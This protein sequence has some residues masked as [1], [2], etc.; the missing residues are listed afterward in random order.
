MNLQVYNFPIFEERLKF[1]KNPS[2]LALEFAE[3][4]PFDAILMDIQ[5]PTLDG[6]EATQQLRRSTNERLRNIPIIAFTAEAA[7][8]SHQDYLNSGF[9]DCMTKPFQPEQLFAVLR[10]YRISEQPV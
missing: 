9:N 4:T 8:E 3:K 6:K 5:M 7:V 10:K 1:Q 2:S